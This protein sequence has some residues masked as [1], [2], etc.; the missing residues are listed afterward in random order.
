MLSANKL[1]I[2]QIPSNVFKCEDGSYIDELSVC[3][4]QNDCTE[5]LDE[6]QCS[7]NYVS[8][9]LAEGCKHISNE[10]SN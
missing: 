9:L 6:K 10:R 4:G 3:D 1:S 7:C 8:H 2:N 5:G